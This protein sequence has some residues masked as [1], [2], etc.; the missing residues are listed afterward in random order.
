[1][2]DGA[3][4]EVEPT[5]EHLR[6]YAI[7]VGL[8]PPNGMP[9]LQ[10]LDILQ[11]QVMAAW[12]LLPVGDAQSEREACAR[13]CEMVGDKKGGHSLGYRSAAWECRDL[14]RGRGANRA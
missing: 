3:G 13:L 7:A 9:T 12:A 10:M 1:M 6:Q 8:V 4:K 2:S 5:L 14:I 11:R